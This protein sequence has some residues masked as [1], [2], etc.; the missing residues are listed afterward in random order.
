MA[1]LSNVCLG[2][3]FVPAL[4]NSGLPNDRFVFEGFLP[5]KKGAKPDIWNLPRKPELL[6][7]MFLPTN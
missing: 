5:E 1:S 6:F 7:S 3:A 4:V 2:N